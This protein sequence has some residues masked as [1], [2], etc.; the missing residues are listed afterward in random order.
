MNQATV[1]DWLR[2][3][4]GRCGH[5][6]TPACRVV[7]WRDVLERLLAL[8]RETG[9][10]EGL[11][12]GSPCFTVEGR[13]VALVSALN[14]H[15]VLSFPEG[16]RLTDPHGL[17][18]LPG[19]HTLQGRVVRLRSVEEVTRLSPALK[20]LL[21]EAMVVATSGPAP[22]PAP[23]V[24]PVP[25][26]LASLLEGDAELRA[27]WHALT[28]GRR[29]SHCLHVGGAAQPATRGRRAEAALPDILAGRGWRER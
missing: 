28:P 7:R 15:A 27:A 4:C 20:A 6:Q 21:A 1:A 25:D 29:R 22:R 9:M 18:D 19:P 26:A 3:G 2:D 24:A 12:W 5:Y 23:A 11:K 13:N 8:V 10:A 14:D 17:L 16:H